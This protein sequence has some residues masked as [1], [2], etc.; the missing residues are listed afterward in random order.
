MN[1]KL[2]PN[3]LSDFRYCIY[4]LLVVFKLCVIQ[5]LTCI[6]FSFLC[7]LYLNPQPIKPAVCPLATC[8]SYQNTDMGQADQNSEIFKTLRYL[9]SVIESIKKPIGTRENPARFCRDMLDCQQKLAD[10]E[11]PTALAHC[12]PT[13]FPVISLIKK[14]HAPHV[15]L[16]PKNVS[17]CRNKEFQQACCF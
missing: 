8:Q 7:M 9:S 5:Y 1:C 14:E 16:Y 11:S 12:L 13:E 15:L 3:P 17:I 10:G 2:W 4:Y 6:W